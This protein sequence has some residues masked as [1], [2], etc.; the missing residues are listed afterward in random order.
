VVLFGTVGMLAYPYLLHSVC[1]S[2]EQ[3]GLVLGVAIHDTSQVLGGALTYKEV[4]ADELAFKVA[5]ITKLTRNV[6]LAGVIPALTYSHVKK[7]EAAEQAEALV[8]RDAADTADSA[9]RGSTVNPNHRLEGVSAPA[10]SGLATFQKYVPSFLLGFLGVA[11]LRTGVDM[12][13]LEEGLLDPVAVKKAVKFLGD[14]CSK[15]CLG[16]AMAS[17]GLS[18][19]RSSLQGVGIKPFLVGGSGALVVGG[20]GFVVA[21]LVT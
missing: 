20:T 19:A 14:D 1:T 15:V 10:I 12:Y 17:V 7:A 21:S 18:T 8:A 2:S 6:F 3:A 9:N 13:M 16:T 11:A 4:Y 5:A